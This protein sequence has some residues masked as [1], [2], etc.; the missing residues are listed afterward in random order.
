M[1]S[2]SHT[3][4]PLPLAGKWNDEDLKTCGANQVLVPALRLKKLWET[5]VVFPYSLNGTVY[6]FGGPQPDENNRNKDTIP[7]FPIYKPCSPR[8]YLNE[9]YN[10]SYIK[11]PN[12]VFRSAPYVTDQYRNWL[13][14]VQKDFAGLWQNYGIFD[15]IQL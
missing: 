8:V 3:K 7:I 11:H 5:Q 9:P 6:A 1:A 10:F 15:L 14:R 12:K 4:E 2:S 13:T